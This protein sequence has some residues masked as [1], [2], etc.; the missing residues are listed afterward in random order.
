MSRN[1]VRP[2]STNANREAMAT[3]H[4]YGRAIELTNLSRV[5]YPGE[6]VMTGD[7]LHYY[8]R[9][10]D[11]I[12]PHLRGR[13][14]S[15]RRFPYGVRRPDRCEIGVPE[16]VPNWVRTY[17]LE[18]REPTGLSSQVIVDEPATLVYLAQQAC[19]TPY[20]WL[21]RAS[22]P[23][24]P[25]SMVFDLDPAGPAKG[26]FDDVCHAAHLL[27]EVVESAGLSPFVMTTGSRGLHVRV[28]IRPSYGFDRV[29][30]L[31]AEVAHEAV[32]ASPHLVTTR[33]L[34]HE[35]EGKVLIDH[36]RNAYGQTVVAPYAL[37]ALPGAPVAT[38]L[39]WEELGAPGNGPR[40]HTIS[41]VF[42]R[43]ARQGDPWKR[44]VFVSAALPPVGGDRTREAPGATS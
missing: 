14:L 20:V 2:F 37:R 13:M 8:C 22:D 31:A 44:M 21:S 12:M 41:S 16:Q 36:R 24:R 38:P 17:E 30:E 6:D 4:I 3:L 10:A 19:I 1:G 26:E 32:R 35:R 29:A 28:P 7:V 11:T 40:D 5:M 34:T 42:S 39:R 9:I 23:S 27:R 18:G 33:A 43:L 25:D 15:M